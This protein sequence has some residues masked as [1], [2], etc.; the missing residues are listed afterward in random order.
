[1]I[2][3]DFDIPIISKENQKKV[4]RKIDSLF[5]EIESG[6]DE[7]K[8]TKTNLE[9]YKQ[10]VLNAAIQGKLV[11]QDPDDEPA[12]KLLERIRAEKEA[13]I[14]VG[15]LRKEKPLPPIDLSKVPFELPKGWE[16]VRI[17]S[18][19][20]NKKYA[21]GIGPFGS[22]L[23]VSD[24]RNGG[25]PLIFVRNIRSNYFG[26][27]KAKYV[28]VTKANELDAHSAEGGD[29]LVTKMGEPPGDACVYP[30]NFPKAIIT[31]D[32][33]KV[34]VDSRFVCRN[35]LS[36]VINSPMAKPQILEQTR[37]VAQKKVSLERFRNLLVP[38]PPIK[39]QKRIQN[40]LEAV[41]QEISHE[42][43]Q[44]DRFL[45]QV[46]SLQQSVLKSAFNGKL[47]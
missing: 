42:S 47:L 22:N 33:I 36:S 15:K 32:C 37:G 28:T 34:S 14:N 13:L 29:V 1:M 17:S 2:L 30:E 40:Y 44:V 18:I 11:P 19:A 25:V 24:Y 31:S 45:G 27:E 38:L 5:S 20:A 16:W 4:V 9:L 46:Q 26:E 35:F 21:M 7:L 10:S 23:K 39:E 6:V 12:S 43:I 41:L 3:G 8:K